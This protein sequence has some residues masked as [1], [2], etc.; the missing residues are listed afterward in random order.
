MNVI[1]NVK[2]EALFDVGKIV[3]SLNI[4]PIIPQPS[5]SYMY[6]LTFFVV[7]LMILK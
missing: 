2:F 4:Y 6:V 3:F 7:E 1:K 5:Q